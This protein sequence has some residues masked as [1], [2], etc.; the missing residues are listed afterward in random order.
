MSPSRR[1][2]SKTNDDQQ[3][4]VPDVNTDQ[5]NNINNNSMAASLDAS[6]RGFNSSTPRLTRARKVALQLDT[7][8]PVAIGDVGTHNGGVKDEDDEEEDDFQNAVPIRTS[9]TPRESKIKNSSFVSE[10]NTGS[11]TSGQNIR[12]HSASHQQ[13]Y[14]NHHHL[15]S[16]PSSHQQSMYI[17]PSRKSTALDMIFDTTLGPLQPP[18]S[19][20]Y[21]ATSAASGGGAGGIGQSSSMNGALYMFSNNNNNI[22]GHHHHSFQ[23]NN[24]LSLGL[25]PSDNNIPAHSSSSVFNQTGSINFNSNNRRGSTASLHNNNIRISPQ[26]NLRSS[27]SNVSAT[28]PQRHSSS[29]ILASSTIQPS[30]SGEI[31]NTNYNHHR[32]SV[33]AG[34]A[35]GTSSSFNNTTNSSNQQQQHQM[36]MATNGSSDRTISPMRRDLI[37]QQQQQQGNWRKH[38]S[39][40]SI[41]QMPQ[42]F[43]KTPPSAE[44]DRSGLNFDDI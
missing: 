1:S 39:D 2:S 42:R 41:N 19:H 44:G 35:I 20:H 38:S 18:L 23:Y 12:A 32:H 4:P 36:M 31:S 33:G 11:I 9:P 17:S 3:Q 25:S 15:S 14:Q 21:S 5:E 30:S 16:S 7:G 43:P 13:R 34:T 27:V 8:E 6:H 37:S 24:S 26:N 10:Q 29:G 40:L 28:S 22:G